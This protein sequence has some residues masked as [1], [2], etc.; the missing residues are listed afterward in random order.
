MTGEEGGS[1]LPLVLVAAVARNGAIGRGGRLI[2]RLRSDMRRFREIT[3]GKPVVMGRKTWDSIGRPLPGRPV[4]VVTHN[5]RFAAEGARTCRDLD[6][7]LD[8]AGVLARGLGADEIIVA[9]GAELYRETIARASR[10][11]LTEV[12]LSPEADAFFPPIDP[13][14][15]RE[16]GREER[17][18]GEQDEA[19]FAFVDYERRAA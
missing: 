14:V 17:Q 8:E 1:R 18:A 6:A 16:I 5:S 2:W 11:R 12:D 4:I 13:S 10:L 3:M 7:A 19:D 9:G 15:W